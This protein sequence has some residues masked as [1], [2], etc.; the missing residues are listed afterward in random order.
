MRERVI[1]R[2]R[3][4]VQGV[5]FRHSARIHAEQLGIRGSA[6]NLNDGLLE[7][8]AEGDRASLEELIAW[9]RTGPPLARVDEIAI[10]WEQPSGVFK[11]FTIL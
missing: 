2:I 11:R 10:T 7:I 4:R 1:I 5:F 6:A 9:C 3:G 8:I